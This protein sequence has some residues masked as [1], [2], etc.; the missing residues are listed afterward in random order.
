MHSSSCPGILEW[1][2]KVSCGPHTTLP[3][4]IQAPHQDQ[5]PLHPRRRTLTHRIAQTA[6]SLQIW[7]SQVRVPTDRP[8]FVGWRF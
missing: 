4:P 5:V 6:S 8:T 7:L 1:R 2:P 3:V